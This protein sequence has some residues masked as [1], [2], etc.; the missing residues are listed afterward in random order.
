MSD[1]V[2]KVE[3]L[4]KKYILSHQSQERYT[5]LCDVMAHGV[6][7][8]NGA[9]FGMGQAEIKRKFGEYGKFAGILS[10][11]QRILCLS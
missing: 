9:I 6:K 8:L 5:A 10:V 2:I 7:L 4:S 1:T 3:N 11:F